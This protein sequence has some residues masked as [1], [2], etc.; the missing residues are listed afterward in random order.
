MLFAQGPSHDGPL[1][2]VLDE[3]GQ[4]GLGHRDEPE[5]LVRLLDLAT[6]QTHLHLEARQEL[7]KTRNQTDLKVQE[8][9]LLRLN[10]E[11][12]MDSFKLLCLEMLLVSIEKAQLLTIRFFFNLKGVDKKLKNTSNVLPL[13]FIKDE[14]MR[15]IGQRS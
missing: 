11:N 1:L 14:K 10:G 12:T 6:R 5:V 4:V 9:G 3:P 2:L 13:H 8:K 7:L 15:E